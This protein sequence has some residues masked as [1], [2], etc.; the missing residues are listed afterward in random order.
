MSGNLR[1]RTPDGV[2]GIRMA[3]AQKDWFGVFWW[4]RRLTG[5]GP[6]LGPVERLGVR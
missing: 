2:R 4:K 3:V 1:A 6:E 5:K